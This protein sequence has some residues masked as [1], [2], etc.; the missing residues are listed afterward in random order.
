[1]D[2]D[3]AAFTMWEFLPDNIRVSLKMA[4]EI[5]QEKRLG[6]DRQV[7]TRECPRCSNKNTINCGNVKDLNDITIGLCP[8]CGYLWCLECEMALL[9]TVNCGHWQVC[10]AC[11]EEKDPSGYCGI[12]PWECTHIISWLK[13]SH[14][15]V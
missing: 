13:K 5:Y 10:T 8:A 4:L 7:S 11:R 14:P 1:M 2:K 12:V 9:T 15:T 6:Q 3:A